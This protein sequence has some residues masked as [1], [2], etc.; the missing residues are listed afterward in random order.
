[1]EYAPLRFSKHFNLDSI[2]EILNTG[3]QRMPLQNKIL[4]TAVLQDIR[5]L[6]PKQLL[7]MVFARDFFTFYYNGP[8]ALLN[9]GMLQNG[10]LKNLAAHSRDFSRELAAPLKSLFQ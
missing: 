4:N 10:P 5:N 2:R 6:E 8:Y 9:K 3:F 7:Q 1:M